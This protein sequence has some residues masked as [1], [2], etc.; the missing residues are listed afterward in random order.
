MSYSA[1]A[2]GP[3]EEQ[4]VALEDELKEYIRVYSIL[5]SEHVRQIFEE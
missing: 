5:P 2:V 4:R 1:G 3:L